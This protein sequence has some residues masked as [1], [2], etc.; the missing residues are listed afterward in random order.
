MTVNKIP[1]TDSIEELARFWDTHD[2]T[3]FDDQ[4]EEVKT[5]VFERRP[6]EEVVDIRLLPDEVEAVERIANSAGVE[7]GTLIHDWVAEKL[8]QLLRA[9]RLRAAEQG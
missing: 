1:D 6:T 5:P 7:V 9:E 2:L 8:D 3:D 4:L